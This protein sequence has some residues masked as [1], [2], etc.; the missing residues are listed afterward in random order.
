LQCRSAADHQTRPAALPPAQRLRHRLQAAVL[1]EREVGPFGLQ[2]ARESSSRPFKIRCRLESLK[3]CLDAPLQ[4]QRSQLELLHSR[5]SG[6]QL[7]GDGKLLSNLAARPEGRLYGELLWRFEPARGQSLQAHQFKPGD[8]V[9][10][11]TE[12]R[13][14]GG[15]GEGS[16]DAAVVEVHGDHLMVVLQ[17]RA[18]DALLD[19]PPGE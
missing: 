17:A 12:E 10:V 11:R 14:S 4:E 19:R 9:F 6:Q 8:S 1:A 13:H 2:M 7:R 18:A 15:G 3:L 16:V 5:S